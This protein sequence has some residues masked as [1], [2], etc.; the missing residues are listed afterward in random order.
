[1]SKRNWFVVPV[2][3]FGISIGLMSCVPK[4][5]KHP[6]VKRDFVA[7]YEQIEAQLKGAC[8]L[9]VGG[10]QISEEKL[11]AFRYTP[12]RRATRRVKW[13]SFRK[14][15]M[16]C[17]TSEPTLRT[18]NQD[19][20]MNVSS[21]AHLFGAQDIDLTDEALLQLTGS[22]LNRFEECA[23]LQADEI[24]G[25]DGRGVSD[26][27]RTWAQDRMVILNEVVTL[28]QGYAVPLAQQLRETG[29]AEYQRKA[30]ALLQ[31][32]ADGNTAVQ[33]DYAATAEEK[34][35]L[36]DYETTV[37]SRHQ[38]LAATIEKCQQS[39][40]STVDKKSNVLESLNTIVSTMGR[41]R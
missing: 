34:K 21:V 22:I 31:A 23:P 30:E 39:L 40:V 8:V 41:K 16:T 33:R 10:V 5:S 6:S 19:S 37:R 20:S 18:S 17:L 1:M 38:M 27:G 13:R 25:F 26:E 11:D 14:A 35:R 29:L 32:A 12:D 9:A 24:A 36:R 15:L 3:V 28:M 4:G 2:V 7:E